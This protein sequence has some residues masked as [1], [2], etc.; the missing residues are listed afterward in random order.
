MT[1]VAADTNVLI[2]F[3]VFDDPDQALRSRAVLEQAERVFVP[4]VVFANLL[5]FLNAAMALRRR[6]SRE[7][8]K[9]WS[10]AQRSSVTKPLCPAV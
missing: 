5:G 8:S 1:A 4:V 2:R 10:T 7:P 9:N 6:I 3:L